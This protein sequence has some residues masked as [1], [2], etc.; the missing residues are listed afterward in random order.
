MVPWTRYPDPRIGFLPFLSFQQSWMFQENSGYAYSFW[1]YLTWPINQP[2]FLYCYEHL[3]NTSL[4]ISFWSFLDWKYLFP[5]SL[6]TKIA[7]Y[8]QSK[9]INCVL[10]PHHALFLR[11]SLDMKMLLQCSGR[12]SFLEIFTKFSQWKRTLFKHFEVCH[13]PDE[14][15]WLFV[16]FEM[17]WDPSKIEYKIIKK[18]WI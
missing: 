18:S 5:P 10:R 9:H 6:F 12:F 16:S 4:C 11:D 8:L 7:L 2:V 1:K 3:G 14:N 13:L 17:T 15:C